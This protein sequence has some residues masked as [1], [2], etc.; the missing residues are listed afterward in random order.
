MQYSTPGFYI[1]NRV[2]YVI[3]FLFPNIEC[4]HDDSLNVLD[5]HIISVTS[6]LIH[7]M[8]RE[9]LSAYTALNHGVFL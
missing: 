9:V 6:L 4:L 7:C 3:Y 1:N 5:R 8:Y 2:F